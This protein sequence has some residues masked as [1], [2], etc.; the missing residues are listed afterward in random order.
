MAS[1]TT[2]LRDLTDSYLALHTRKEDLFW[3]SKMGLSADAQ[4]AT[5][6]LARAEIELNRFVQ[7]PERLKQL[8]DL[9]ASGAGSDEDRQVLHGWI[10]ML[11]ARV[12]E[13][14]AARRLSEEIVEREQALEH[15]RGTMPLGF[16]DPD[17]GIFTAASSVRLALMMRVDHDERRRR[18]AFDALRSIEPFVLDHGFLEIV[19]MRNRLGRLLGYEDYYDWKVSTVEG[20]SKRALFVKL[21]DLDQR[22][23]ARTTQDLAAFEQV[24]GPG[25]REP[26]NFPFLRAGKLTEALD[27]YFQFATALRRWVQSFTGLSVRFRQATLTLD[28]LDRSGK[29][30]NGFMHGPVP[31]FFDHDRWQP[32]RI[33]FTANAVAGQVG[34]GLRAAETLFHEGGHAA[35]FANILSKAPCFSQEFAPTSV[36]YAETQSMFMDALLGDADWR[37]RYAADAHGATMPLELIEQ[38]VRETQALRGWTVRSMLTVPFAERAIYELTEKERTPERVLR[39]IRRIE[40]ALQGLDAGPRPVLAI[41]HLL[42]GESSAYYHGYVLAE[43]AVAQTRAYLLVRDGYLTDNPRVGH[44]LATHYWAKGNAVPFEATLQSLTGQSLSADALADVCNQPVDLA[45]ADARAAASRASTAPLPHG[46]V[47]LDAT[48]HVV[49][50]PERIASTDDGGIDGMCDAFE[51][52]INRLEG[53]AVRA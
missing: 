52:W 30:E 42:S 38:S 9:D 28:L 37:I 1:L 27:P 39:D 31:A 15:A 6:D 29:Y 2:T 33:A 43:M 49:H 16:V 32:A 41:P 14:P 17:T 19:G 51:A 10:A 4:R 45:V 21:D 40:S 8:R 24:H 22:T 53:A 5:E 20:M 26:W 36:A 34:S 23:A 18:A 35:H 11:A 13:D 25:S 50:G 46:P 44:D 47:D 7:S 3:Q 12:I 48:I